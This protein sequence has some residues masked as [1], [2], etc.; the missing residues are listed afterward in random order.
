MYLS[1]ILS[2]CKLYSPFAFF[3]S[4]ASL[5]AFAS[6]LVLTHQP[7]TRKAGRMDRIYGKNGKE[8]LRGEVAKGKERKGQEGQ[9]GERK[10]LSPFFR[11][12]FSPK[13]AFGLIP[14]VFQHFRTRKNIFLKEKMEK[15]RKEFIVAA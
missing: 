6:G 15:A 11:V 9:K 8:N 2:K 4:R 14:I 13:G 3:L 5:T 7:L 1:F 12:W 10:G